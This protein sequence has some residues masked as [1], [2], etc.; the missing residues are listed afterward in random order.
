MCMTKRLDLK[1]ARVLG[2]NKSEKRYFIILCNKCLT[3]ARNI[4]VTISAN[5]ECCVCKIK[6]THTSTRW[7]LFASAR[8]L[9][10]AFSWRGDSIQRAFYLNG[11]PRLLNH[12]I[13]TL[14]RI[15]G[16]NSF[17]LICN[18]SL[19]TTVYNSMVDSDRWNKILTWLPRKKSI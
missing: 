11:T 14:K 16:I 1:C 17:L 5:I 2:N 7:H 13:C 10:A 12:T 18:F 19:C 8:S 9:N 15:S 6:H 3:V 4:K